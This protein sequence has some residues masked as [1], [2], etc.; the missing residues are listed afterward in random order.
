MVIFISIALLSLLFIA[1]SAWLGA[2]DGRKTKARLERMV[3]NPD[4]MKRVYREGPDGD[5]YVRLYVETLDGQVLK[6]ADHFDVD[7][8]EKRLV[9]N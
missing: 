2:C 4:Q 6:V 8:A 1:V 3:A 9:A 7:A 5:G